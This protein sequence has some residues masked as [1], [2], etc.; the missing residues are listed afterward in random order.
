MCCDRMCSCIKS[1]DV[2]KS[3]AVVGF[4]CMFA[5]MAALVYGLVIGLWA[6]KEMA[7]VNYK[8]ADCLVTGKEQQRKICNRTYCY[9]AAV[10]VDLH[11]TSFNISTVI[12]NTVTGSWSH[13]TYYRYLARFVIGN[14]YTCYYNPHDPYTASWSNKMPLG[15]S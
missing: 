7:V 11:A 8:Q 4:V 5:V 12:Y 3:K 1:A 13:S 2:W 9:R 15:R 14:W 10:Y 6:S